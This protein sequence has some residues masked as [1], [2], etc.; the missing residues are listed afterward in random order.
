METPTLLRSQSAKTKKTKV[1]PAPKSLRGSSNLWASTEVAKAQAAA[2]PRKTYLGHF[3]KD[4]YLGLGGR[5]SRKKSRKP[6]KK[7]RRRRTRKTKRKTKRKTRKKR[8]RGLGFSRPAKVAA[9]GALA[10]VSGAAAVSPA[11]KQTYQDIMQAP[12]DA[13]FRQMILPHHPDK[14][15]TVEGFSFVEMARQS[16]KKSCK[17]NEKN[18]KTAK[19]PS[20]QS[21]KKWKQWQKKIRRE[22]KEEAIKQ[23]QRTQR[24]QAKEEARKQSERENANRKSGQQNEDTTDYGDMARKVGATAAVLGGLEY[25]RRR[26]GYGPNNPRPER[27]L[28]PPRN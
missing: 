19:P 10:L 20:G 4:T 9:V 1:T 16:R 5:K 7:H 12:C 8:G 3:E 2:K 24:R 27:D 28:T 22:A 6:K 26:P 25:V 11:A 21:R 13:P 17:K 23:Q 15:G 18:E 14:G